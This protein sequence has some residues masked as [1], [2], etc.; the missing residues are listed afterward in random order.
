MTTAETLPA[1]LASPY[2]GLAPYEDTETDAL[3][4]FGRERDEEIIAANL[5]VS[6]LTVLYGPSGVGKSSVLQAGV[7]RQIRT[8]ADVSVDG[9]ADCA[10]VVFSAWSADP[11]AGLVQAVQDAVESVVGAPLDEQYAG[12]PL[13]TA[14]RSLSLRLNGDLYLILDQVEEYFLYHAGGDDPGTFGY[15]FPDA[16]AEPNLRVHFL[17]SIRDDALAQ[18]DRFKGRM[19][20]L[21]SNYLRLDR[22]DRRAGRAAI[23]GP[24]N[25]YNQLAAGQEAIQIEGALVE[26][27]LDEVTVGRVELGRA[28]PAEPQATNGA[29]RIEAPYLQLV[30]QRLW[31]AE[32]NAQST[33][34]RLETLR[35]LGGA[36][37]IVEAHLDRALATLSSGERDLAATAFNYLV[38][39]SGTKIAHDAADLAQYT[40]AAPG[41]LEH[42]LSA[43]G[44]E[45]ILRS[46]SPE[47]GADGVSYEIFHDVLAQAVLAWRR[48][49]E[50]ER[51][52]GRERRE[53]EKR[54]RRLLIVA[55]AALIALAA[56]AALAVFA[57]TQ[58]GEAR[59]QAT[60][61][62]ARAA[63]AQRQSEAA[64]T[65]SAA[66]DLASR[67]ASGQA[68]RAESR[69]LAATAL[70]QLEID[71]EL[72][73]LL[74]VRAAQLS[75]SSQVR[76]A[77]QR[78]LLESH[79][80]LVLRSDGAVHTAAYSPDGTRIVTASEDGS[81][82]IFDAKTGK[83]LQ[84]LDHD[85]PV[86]KAVFN[87]NGTLVA[88]ASADRNVHLWQADSGLL[89]WTFK[90]GGAVADVAF[91]PEGGR[92]CTASSD[93]YVRVFDV[94]SDQPLHA[95]Q[96]PAAVSRCVFS[97]DGSSFFTIAADNNLRIYEASSGRQIGQLTHERPI[98]DAAF[99]PDGRVVVSAS[100]D[101]SLGIW[102]AGGRSGY[103]RGAKLPFLSVAF[104]RDGSLFTN[105]SADGAA[106][107][108]RLRDPQAG[109]LDPQRLVLMNGHT[110]RVVD[111]EF[112][113]DDRSVVTASLDRTARTWEAR[114]GNSVAVLAGH[115]DAVTSA[116]FA[117][118]SAS[119]LTASDDGTARV[120]DPGTEAELR[121]LGSHNAP[122]AMAAYSPDGN[123]MVTASSDGTARIWSREG[124]PLQ[125]LRHGGAVSAAAFSPDGSL[126]GTVG[127]N[128]EAKLWDAASGRLLNTLNAATPLDALA[129]APDGRRLTAGGLNGST[130]VWSVP[131]GAKLYVLEGSRLPV[132]AVAYSPDGKLLLTAG[133]D[134]N[135]RIWDMAS[136]KALHLL[137][138]HR[139]SVVDAT[140]SPDGALVITASRD[141]T[142][143]LWDVN[144]GDLVHVLKGH[145]GPL[146]SAE[147]SADGNSVVTA[148]EDRDARIWSV[149]TGDSLHALV[150]HFAVVN[151]A[152]FS[153]DG[154][155]VAT[156]GPASSILWEASTGRLITYLHGP[157]DR[158]TSVSFS[159]DASRVLTSSVDGGVRMY[160]CDIC[161]PLQELLR[162]AKA[163]L[164]L[165]G[166]TLTPAE[167]QQY[168]EG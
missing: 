109:V 74:S 30:M 97:A 13:V 146:T 88:T 32:Q 31:E 22:L 64:R 60:L 112:S 85:G 130:H 133:R 62:L 67:E 163:R 158:L 167:E 105:G 140:F 119:V 82:R 125:V 128:G 12:V 43:L 96:Q 138:G 41:E 147:F 34:L 86:A 29:G 83:A 4:F 142:A 46:F 156:A 129:F 153:P 168:L 76:D 143:R 90:H 139:G 33:T 108:W 28:T 68:R 111:S 69:A 99:A 52:L 9:R 80:R 136:G 77:L 66:A 160:E 61:A 159:P 121:L 57:F 39:P 117:P 84:R 157:T 8:H 20:N 166:R 152:V 107:T 7:A 141:R 55:V 18:L 75:P 25:R 14:L 114:G 123:L 47:E 58:R 2:K 72:S 154:R 106:R 3:L 164:A 81:A 21:F 116:T 94:S 162:V 17:L 132:T 23:V 70:G 42:V 95:E 35:N 135:A 127:D 92:L 120:W 48:K 53:A 50:A 149:A 26:A 78:S 10:V 102:V 40:G 11:V 131:D 15:E 161:G 137:H 87:P 44:A 1:M 38:T 65:A 16:V 104:N 79:V 59:S 89:L 101:R 19:P 37:E 115:T 110:N 71:P 122:V 165:T 134:H 45:R 5:M 36:T 24:L 49:H 144:T 145:R 155:F 98:F 51:A 93:G 151:G 54:H 124:R 100:A 150:G 27:V 103:L 113:P 6:R 56:M 63:E 118:D 91:S 126:V 148:S 73:L